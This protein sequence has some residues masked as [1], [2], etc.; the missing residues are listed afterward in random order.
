MQQAKKNEAALKWQSLTLW[1]NK[2]IYLFNP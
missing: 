1:H 2:K